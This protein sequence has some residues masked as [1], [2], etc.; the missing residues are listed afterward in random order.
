MSFKVMV[1]LIFFEI[2]WSSKVDSTGHISDSLFT[3]V[4][5]YTEWRSLE[6]KLRLVLTVE[7]EI[8]I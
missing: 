6:V 2:K 8:D 3:I 7:R 5:P 4:M 1:S